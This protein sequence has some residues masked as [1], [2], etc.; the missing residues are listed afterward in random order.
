[1]RKTKI[2]FIIFFATFP[3]VIR[4]QD[5]KSSK[6]GISFGFDFSGLIYKTIQ[7]YQNNYEGSIT[8]GAFKKFYFTLEAGY[9]SMNENKK[10]EFNYSGKGDYFRIGFDYNIYKKKFPTDNNEIIFGLRYGNSWMTH[11]ANSITI[12]DDQWGN[13]STNYPNT[14]VNAQWIEAAGGLRVEILKNFSMGWTL[15]F[16]R[17][18]SSSG[19]ENIKPFLIPGFGDGAGFTS[20]GFNYSIYYMIPWN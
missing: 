6:S 5:I 15:R 18:I 16:R 17:L 13:Y 4:S 2:I 19:M 7:P 12:V 1:M 9:L 8:A 14:K 10:D 20:F 11:S 3:V